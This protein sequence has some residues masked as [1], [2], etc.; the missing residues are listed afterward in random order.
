M[1]QRGRDDS[2]KH[3]L[4]DKS[5]KDVTESFGG[6][7]VNGHL[8]TRAGRVTLTCSHRRRIEE[9]CRPHIA[10]RKEGRVERSID[11]DDKV[12]IVVP[13]HVE[14]KAQ[15]DVSGQANHGD[16]HDGHVYE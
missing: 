9:T 6:D 13:Y 10:Y 2:I 12:P 3:R 1:R 11:D 14:P 5:V 16:N 8:C 15:L 7:D 4:S